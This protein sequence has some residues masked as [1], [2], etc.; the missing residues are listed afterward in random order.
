[1]ILVFQILPTVAAAFVV[2]VTVLYFLLKGSGGE[3][4][5]KRPSTLQDP[6]V[7]Y[8]LPLIEKQV[9]CKEIC[10][11]QS[12]QCCVIHLDSFIHIAYQYLFSQ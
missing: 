6:T 10:T 12:H 3:K 9:G 1:M 4:K 8:S 7:K 11:L 2:V 5:K